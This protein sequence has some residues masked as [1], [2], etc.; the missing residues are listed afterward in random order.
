MSK[1]SAPPRVLVVDD[2]PLIRWSLNETLADRG[3][4][5]VEA[6]TGQAALEAVTGASAPFEVLILDLRL[7]DSKDLTLLT[8]IR[9]LTPKTQVILMTAFGTQEVLDGAIEL[10]AYRVVSKPFEVS[11]LASLVGQAHASR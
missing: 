2:E 5:V 9:R 11:A 3:Y 1:Q 10:G 7:P 8:Q 6:G 4:D